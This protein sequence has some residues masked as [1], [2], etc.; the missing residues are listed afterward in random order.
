MPNRFF[1]DIS[2]NN[3][4]TVDWN[5]YRNKGGHVLVGLKA[6]EGES[7]IDK[8]HASRSAHA[9]Q[10]GVWVAHY[11]FGHPDLNPVEQAQFFW[12]QVK[13]HFAGK[14]FACIDIEVTGGLSYGAVGQ[15]VRR[16]DAEFR[17]VSGHTLVGYS[18]EDFLAHMGPCGI[19]R[20]WVAKY[21][22][23]PVHA[24]A[25]ASVWAWQM[26]DGEV[27]PGPKACAG[28][29]GCDVSELNRLTYWRL[30]LQKPH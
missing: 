17:R 23:P 26:N 2:N 3:T 4:Q 8:T 21:G 28:I 12:A 18:G 20:W 24:P 5:A 6:S 14:D 27:G 19:K 30:R 29:G 10:A 11:H 15:W 9:H 16:F 13:P 7:F 25:G 1:A 22:P